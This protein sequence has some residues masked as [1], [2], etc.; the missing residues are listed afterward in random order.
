MSILKIIKQK[1][2]FEINHYIKMILK[3]VFQK[4]SSKYIFYFYIL[5]NFTKLF[6]TQF[7]KIKLKTITT[8]QQ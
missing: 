4:N 6:S 3:N 5:Q 2:F 1:A 7:Q 8:R